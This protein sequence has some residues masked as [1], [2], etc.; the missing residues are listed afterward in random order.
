MDLK[1]FGV[2]QFIIFTKQ[3][4]VQCTYSRIGIHD[5][6]K[7]DP[8]PQPCMSDKFSSWVAAEVL[9]DKWNSA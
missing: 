3:Y 2:I 4:S 6:W 1:N 8:G 9:Y 7:W 5:K